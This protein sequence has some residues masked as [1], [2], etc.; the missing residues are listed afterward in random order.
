GSPTSSRATSP[1]TAPTPVA[2]PRPAT[3]SPR[4]T[5][6]WP[7]T[8]ASSSS[9]AT[10]ATTGTPSP[11]ASAATP[12]PCARSSTAPWP[13]WRASW[14]WRTTMPDGS[15]LVEL[16]VR[17]RERWRRGERIT[18]EKLLAEHPDFHPDDDARLDLIYNEVLLR[19]QAGERP[20]LDDYLPRFP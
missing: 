2:R 4:S 8:N 13:A 6:G 7:P 19:E 1:A 3:S 10:R 16:I 14:A 9:C 17:L 18:V 20:R 12:R 15:S 5:A 11:S